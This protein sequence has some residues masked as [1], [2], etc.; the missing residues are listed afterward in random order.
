MSYQQVVDRQKIHTCD[1]NMSNTNYSL[2]LPFN[3]YDQ[4]DHRFKQSLERICKELG[5]DAVGELMDF[6]SQSQQLQKNYARQGLN[7]ALAVFHEAAYL[8]RHHRFD[9][10]NQYGY[11]SKVLKKQAQVILER[12]GFSRT[13]A[14][15]LVKTASWM[16][17]THPGKD[18]LKWFES[19][20]PSHLYEL[21]R[22]SDEAYKAVKD[23]VSYEGWHFCTG[24]KSISVRRLEQIRRLYPTV[25]EV[26]SDDAE[27]FQAGDNSSLTEVQQV[28]REP[29]LENCSES[30][31]VM[32]VSVATNIE[33]L[34]QLVILAK[35]ID[36]TA[37]RKSD[38][39]QEILS[40]MPAT[41][42]LLL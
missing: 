41:I 33:K 2:L 12:L 27:P 3:K 24:Q 39:S 4:P 25:E 19:L 15:K 10:D 30:G 20:T 35:T 22:M 1:K 21:S 5:E 13:N 36:W 17:T 11:K 6:V 42:S 8:D 7:L 9:Q 34:R 40:S 37:V 32:D 28:R 29:A 26:K 18:E 14:H 16:V 23:E 38:V 31:V